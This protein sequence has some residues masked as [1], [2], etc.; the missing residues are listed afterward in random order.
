MSTDTVDG[1]DTCC[2][3]PGDGQDGPSEICDIPV[4]APP[5]KLQAQAH[6]PHLE[7]LNKSPTVH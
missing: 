5:K 2:S 1:T 6:Q 3:G 7:E 4:S